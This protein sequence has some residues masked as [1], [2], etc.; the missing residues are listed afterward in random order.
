MKR[1]VTRWES[2]I[3]RMPYPCAGASQ[4]VALQTIFDEIDPVSIFGVSS[5]YMLWES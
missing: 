2:I 4:P 5:L 3:L 1:I